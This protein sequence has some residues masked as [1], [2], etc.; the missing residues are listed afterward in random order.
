MPMKYALLPPEK[1]PMG[2][3]IAAFFANGKA[4]KLRVLSSMF[5]EDEMPVKELFCDVSQMPRL[6]KEALRLASG[7]ILDVGAGTGRHS[8]ALQAQGKDVSAIDISL[9][10]VQTMR[11]RGVKQVQQ[12]HFFDPQFLGEYDTILM[13]MNGS[14]IIGKVEN[15]PSFFEKLKQLL[16]PTGSVLIDSSD[17]SFLYE[18]EDGGIVLDLNGDYYG[19]VDYQMQYENIKGD[20]FSWLYIDFSTLELY[21]SQYGFKVEKLLEGAHYDYLARISRD[22]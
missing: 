9:L 11:K 2:A 6:E 15:L 10:S 12:I 7:K 18:D 5:D 17:L 3:A 19:E 1:D 21:A 14:G 4:S 8:L 13:L 16:S 20:S 22:L